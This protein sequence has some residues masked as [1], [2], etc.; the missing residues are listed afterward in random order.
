MVDRL[1]VELDVSDN[2]SDTSP[3]IEIDVVGLRQVV[4][5]TEVDKGQVGEADA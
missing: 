5:V 2:G 1:L 4:G 3:L